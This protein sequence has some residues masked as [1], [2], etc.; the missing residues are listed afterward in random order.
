M[1]EIIVI[2]LYAISGFISI[3]AYWP[4][5]KLL[6]KAEN[7]ATEISIKTWTIWTIENFIALLYGIV[8]LEDLIFCVLI[9]LDV[10]CMITIVSLVI[11]NRYVVFGNSPNLFSAFILHYFKNPNGSLLKRLY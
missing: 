11:H 7:A 4:Q 8:A 1:F 6:F 9:G 3:A 5:I 10:I 2:Q